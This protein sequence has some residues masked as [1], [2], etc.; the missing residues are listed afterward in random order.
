M[1]ESTISRAGDRVVALGDALLDEIADDDEQDDVE[2]LEAAQ[3]AASEI[4]VRPNTKVKMTTVA[5]DEIHYG[6]T[7]TERWTTMRCRARL[8]ARRSRSADRG[9]S[10]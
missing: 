6:Q 4:R 1:V 8:R 3:L 5:N 2:R 9:S 7:M 10:G